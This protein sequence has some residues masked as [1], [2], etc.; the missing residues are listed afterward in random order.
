MSAL[1]S[2]N[3]TNAESSSA[4]TSSISV[5][6]LGSVAGKVI[7]NLGKI[8]LK[9]IEKILINRKL[10]AISRLMFEAS[11]PE[12]YQDVLEQARCESDRLLVT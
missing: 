7:V 5:R 2:S 3:A 8:T 12:I 11:S 10:Y 9:G 1:S 4:G 6:G